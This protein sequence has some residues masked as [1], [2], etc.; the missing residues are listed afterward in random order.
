MA[1]AAGTNLLLAPDMYV[2]TS[3]LNMLSPTGKC[4]M[5]S[6]AADGYS[7]GEGVACVIL[8][9]VPQALHDGD[10]IYA[11][12][13]E[14]GVNQDGRTTGI[15]MPSSTAQTELIRETYAKAGLD[16][17][18]A[19]DRC[20][21]FEAH[22]TG[23]PAGDPIEAQAIWDAFFTTPTNQSAPPEQLYVGSVKTVVGHLEG[24]AGL[25]GVIKACLGL[26][27]GFIPSNLHLGTPN[28]KIAPMLGPGKLLVPT[29]HLPWPEPVKSTD[30]AIQIPRR[31]SV[32]SFGFGGTNAHAILESFD[33]IVSKGT[34]HKAP[35]TTKQPPVNIVISA[36][37][38][39]SLA[40]LVSRYAD[41][42]EAN[43]DLNLDSLAWTTQK[44]R[45]R[46][47]YGI[48]FTG[49]SRS[50]LVKQMRTSVKAYHD[51]SH[52]GVSS[53]TWNSS[54][55]GPEILGVF[56]GQGA[57]WATMG[58]K[59]L[60]ACP[61]FAQSIARLE[62]ALFDTMAVEEELSGSSKWSLST[63]LRAPIGES[64]IAEAE[65][66][67]PL[68]TAVQVAL[69]DTL[70]SVGVN[71]SAV[72]GHSSDDALRD[73]QLESDTLGDL[74][75]LETVEEL[76][77]YYMCNVY[78]SFTVAEAFDETRTPWFIRRFWEWLHH[79]L[80]GPG[81]GPHSNYVNPW[82]SDPARRSS[83]MRR[84]DRIKHRVEVQILEAVAANIL[85]VMRQEDGPT[86]LEVLF[87]NDM[88]ARLYVEPAMYA[89][90]NRYLGRVASLI[91]HRFP[92]CDILEVGAG[93]GGATQAMFTGL[94][95]TY[96]SYTFT[97]ISSG[98]FP[99]AKIKFADEVRR[100]IFKT[101]DIETDVVDQALTPAT[102]DIIVAS[103]V[104]HATRDIEAS[105]K[106]MRKLL[107]PGGFLLLLE[108]T[109]VDKV[110]VPYLMGA[111]PGWWYFEDRWRKDTFSPLLTTEKWHEVLQD[112][113]FQT[114]TE[115]I[116]RDMEHP[117]DH[118]SS[119]MVARA[120]DEDWMAFR[121]CVPTST[122]EFSANSLVIVKG[123]EENAISHGMALEL[124]TRILGVCG[125]RVTVTIVDGL[126]TA[127]ASSLLPGSM[128]IVLSDIESPP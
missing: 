115:H 122:T 31:A 53:T 118:L 124:R 126:Q 52:I 74:E 64:R 42:L 76:A 84:V 49:S 72:I 1:V 68:S 87:R 57:Q 29:E 94:G 65:F 34:V 99:Q 79:R 6:S 47:E 22:G 44:R 80:E 92:R 128:V 14:T 13:R 11:V 105:L 58:A 100:M 32:N 97:D 78:E 75:G 73:F 48:S 116:F 25:A 96:G 70:R 23:T 39:P 36:A 60:D 71:F 33:A 51:G 103:N 56:T 90:A 10:R 45:T 91:A 77:H 93:T 5:W 119:V 117:E 125:D 35:K 19:E 37:K 12:V 46:L 38:E 67:Q 43:P 101:L 85:R 112:S 95:G 127:A 106:N 81:G 61:A 86:I 114:G 7:R 69:V 9:T 3:N 20:Q 108:V 109:S 16:L 120:T 88:L 30:P 62:N 2:M 55:E 63:E 24:C 15:T 121:K 4:Q 83:L 27:Q 26:H 18:K 8:K 104:L 89:R 107:K 28:P 111:V 123:K 21:F 59:L 54:S 110:L 113:G 17:R 98:F 40:S 50:I 41:Y 102:Y 66:A 82:A